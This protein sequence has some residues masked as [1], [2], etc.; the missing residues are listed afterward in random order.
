MSRK[1]DEQDVF[2]KHNAPDNGKF[3]RRPRSQI[4]RTN[5][6][7]PVERSCHKNDHVQYGSSSILF[8]LIMT[9]VNFFKKLVKCQGQKV[10]YQLEDLITRDSQWNIKALALTIQKL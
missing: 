6:L 7:I 9:N 1:M 4:T 10:E 8:I 2:V 5:I 3:Q